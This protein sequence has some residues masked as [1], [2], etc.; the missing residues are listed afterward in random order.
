MYFIMPV[1]PIYSLGFVIQGQSSVR[2]GA[3]G[4]PSALYRL[5]PIGLSAQAYRTATGAAISLLQ[6]STVL[7]FIIALAQT[8]FLSPLAI[9]NCFSV[10][11][12][13]LNPLPVLL[14]LTTIILPFSALET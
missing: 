11:P 3:A 4:K 6:T 9:A 2:K 10:S 8:N 14:K 1:H 13:A 12:F 5:A 7:P